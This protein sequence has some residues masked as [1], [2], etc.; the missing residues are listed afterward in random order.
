MNVLDHVA[1]V[2]D[3]AAFDTVDELHG[4]ARRLAEEFPSLARLRRIGSSRLGEPL[5]CLTVGDGPRDA[6]VVGFPHPNEPFG[7][8]TALHL[9]RSVCEDA[10]LRAELG[11][12]WHIAYCVDPGRR[13]AER[14]VVRAAADPRAI[15]A[16]V[17]PAGG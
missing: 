15:R 13:A 10:A 6:L 12:T 11:F 16:R 2:P 8:L 4:R 7:G 14:V 5:W 17:L 3:F 1:A 9:A